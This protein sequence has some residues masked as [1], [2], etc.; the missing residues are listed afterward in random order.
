MSELKND[1][2]IEVSETWYRG[3]TEPTLTMDAIF[4]NNGPEKPP[5]FCCWVNFPCK[6]HKDVR[7]D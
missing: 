5:T 4:K 3:D 7:P 1:D 2:L 6:D